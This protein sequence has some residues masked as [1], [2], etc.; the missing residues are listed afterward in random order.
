MLC[1]ER[2]FSSS[3]A[4]RDSISLRSRAS[5]L[6]TEPAY[7]RSIPAQAVS[8]PTTTMP[9]NHTISINGPVLADMYATGVPAMDLSGSREYIMSA[10]GDD[11]TN[12]F[13]LVKRI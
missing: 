3:A 8:N 9:R 13:L 7:H 5:F 11:Y 4:D 1:A 10:N 12:N 6:R 2:C